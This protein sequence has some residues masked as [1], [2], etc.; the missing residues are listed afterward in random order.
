[1][2][3]AKDQIKIYI[4]SLTIFG[5]FALVGSL[6]FISVPGENRDILNMLI[7]FMGAAFMNVVSHY[8]G[9]LVGRT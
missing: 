8:F 2:P 5:F 6:L 7:G 1:M 9:E 4:A 3:T